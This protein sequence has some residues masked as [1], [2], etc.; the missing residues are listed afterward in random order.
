MTGEMET[1]R[2]LWAFLEGIFSR[3]FSARETIYAFLKIVGFNP[4]GADCFFCHRKEIVAFFPSDHIFLCS[5]HSSK[6]PRDKVVL[7]K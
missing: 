6:V 3:H 1:D 5:A 2:K 7:L 4:D